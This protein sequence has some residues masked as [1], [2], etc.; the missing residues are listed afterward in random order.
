MML[1][2]FG[3]FLC[4]IINSALGM[5][6]GTILAPVL[7]IAG[8]E[9]TIAIP[10]VLLSQSFG[11]LVAAAMHHRK[12]NADFSFKSTDPRYIAERL[13]KIG[14][15]ETFKRGTSKDLKV[16]L[17]IMILGV[18]A[19]V[20]AVLVAVNVSKL[21]LKTYIGALVI[22]MGL[23][24]LS[25]MRFIFSWKKIIG[26]GVLSSFNKALSGGGFGPVVTSGQM[27]GGRDGKNSIGSTAL[28][29]A[30][31]CFAGFLSYFLIKGIT[32]WRLPLLLSLGAVFGALIGPH[33]TSKFRSERKI[34][35]ILGILVLALG[36]WVLINTWFFQIK[37]F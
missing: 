36:G 9:P 33:F 35:I 24:L 3:S 27:I 10:S 15:K 1:L 8:F 17:S 6:Y 28:A 5:L 2:L 34:R 22:V 21:V 11:G 13:Q 26:L 14:Y 29:E 16:S 12:N 32:D 37:G 23:V 7:L 25:Q 4:S 19:A 31:I 20:F 18:I 30:P